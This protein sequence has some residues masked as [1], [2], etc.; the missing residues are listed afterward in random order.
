MEATFTMKNSTASGVFCL[1]TAR[2]FRA[3]A[4][5]HNFYRM[6]LVTEEGVPHFKVTVLSVSGLRQSSLGLG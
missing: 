5:K 6:F 4:K 1:E 3:E 2:S